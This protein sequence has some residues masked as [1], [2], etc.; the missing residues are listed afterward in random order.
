MVYYSKVVNVRYLTGIEAHM[1]DSFAIY[2]NPAAY[3]V[4]IITP[5]GYTDIIMITDMNG[6]LHKVMQAGSNKVELDVSN[7][8]SGVYL[9][10]FRNGNKQLTRQLIVK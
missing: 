6:K 10:V 2:P 4:N 8:S 3:S 9:V 5:D 1:D 7:M